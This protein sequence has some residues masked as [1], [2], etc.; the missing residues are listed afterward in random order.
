MCTLF[1]RIFA[2]FHPNMILIPIFT[3]ILLYCNCHII[4]YKWQQNRKDKDNVIPIRILVNEG[5]VPD[6][7]DNRHNRDQNA[8]SNFYLNNT[9]H[10]KI[11]PEIKFIT[12]AVVYLHVALLVIRLRSK[13]FQDIDITLITEQSKILL[14]ALDLGP[15]SLLMLLY[16]IMFYCSHK[17]LRT[18]WKNQF[19][20]FR[21]NQD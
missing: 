7:D 13:M 17:E 12:C 6:A 16:P 1:Y 14:Y 4:Y 9:V 20:C 18:Y 10:N 11:L 5:E 21:R 3:I 8:N 15:T 2:P 19:T